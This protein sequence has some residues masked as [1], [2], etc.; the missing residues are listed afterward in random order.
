MFLQITFLFISIFSLNVSC[1]ENSIPGQVYTAEQHFEDIKALLNILKMDNPDNETNR[2][3]DSMC[4]F[5][6]KKLT[7]FKNKT[8]LKKAFPFIN[9]MIHQRK[10]VIIPGEKR[11]E[12][13]IRESKIKI[14]RSSELIRLYEAELKVLEAKKSFFK[15]IADICSRIR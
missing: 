11:D 7:T 13:Y 8:F 6:E 12:F 3:V 5:L 1:L 10:D 9:D 2:K 4:S 15:K 14:K